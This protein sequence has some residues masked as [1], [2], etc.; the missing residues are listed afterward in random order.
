ML[1]HFTNGVG[2]AAGVA[3]VLMGFKLGLVAIGEIQKRRR[4]IEPSGAPE[5]DIDFRDSATINRALICY[6]GERNESAKQQTEALEEIGKQ[7]EA[8]ARLL[9]DRANLPPRTK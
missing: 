7:A 6:W 2:F 5:L 4:R 9:A 8:I 3:A 1:E